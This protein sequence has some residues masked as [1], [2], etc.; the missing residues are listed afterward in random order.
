MRLMARPKP[1]APARP[2]INL[3]DM[4]EGPRPSGLLF[5][6]VFRSNVFF[7]APADPRLRRTGA[8]ALLLRPA[9]PSEAGAKGCVTPPTH[10][11]V[12]CRRFAVRSDCHQWHSVYIFRRFTQ[13]HLFC[14]RADTLIWWSFI[15]ALP[16]GQGVCHLFCR[17]VPYCWIFYLCS[18]LPKTL[19]SGCYQWHFEHVT[20]KVDWFFRF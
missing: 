4:P 3:D 19:L 6:N 18:V 8:S 1:V 17:C 16:S 20:A 10:R 2:L 13:L 11:S 15:S 12:L 14:K 9:P 5:A 7:E